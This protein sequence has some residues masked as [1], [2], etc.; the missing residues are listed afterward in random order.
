MCPIFIDTFFIKCY[1]LLVE[2]AFRKEVIIMSLKHGLLGLLNYAPMTGYELD[3]TFKD[4][5]SFFWQANTSQVYRELNTMENLGWLSSEQIIQN[6]K[7]NKRVYTI[8]KDGKKELKEWIGI[9]EADIS[10]ALCVKSAFLMRVFFAG[11][12]KK[13]HSIKIL[14]KYREKCLEKIESMQNAYNSISSYGDI[15]S[16]DKRVNYWKITAMFGDEFYHAGV[17]WADKAIA[18]LEEME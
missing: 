1:I 18:I 13:E 5:L 11:E 8:T 6:D 17:I 12:L 9:P 2:Y 16:N 3:R 10:D 14:H 7:P 15:V 4:S